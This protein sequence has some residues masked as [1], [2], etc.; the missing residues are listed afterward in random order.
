[1]ALFNKKETAFQ[2]FRDPLLVDQ[3]KKDKE[4]VQQFDGVDASRLELLACEV[5]VRPVL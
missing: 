1:M 4:S 5:W 2:G 3:K